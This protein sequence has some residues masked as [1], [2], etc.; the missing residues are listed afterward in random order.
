MTS[1]HRHHQWIRPLR[2]VLPVRSMLLL[3]VIV[4]IVTGLAVA[5]AVRM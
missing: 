2:Q 4:M 3:A 1:S 5:A